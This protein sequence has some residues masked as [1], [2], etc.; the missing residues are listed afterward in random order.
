MTSIQNPIFDGHANLWAPTVATA[1]S[2]AT[3]GTSLVVQSGLGASA[4]ATPFN[5]VLYPTSA[6]NVT[7]SNSE[8]VRVTAVSTDTLTIVRSQ[9]GTTAQSVT[10]SFSIAAVVS[11][12][13]L[14][15]IERYARPNEL[16]VKLAPY[17]SSMQT[18]EYGGAYSGDTPPIY[19]QTLFS[20]DA[21]TAG[22]ITKIKITGSAAPSSTDNAMTNNWLQ[23][24]YD[25][26]NTFPFCAELGTLFGAYPG[27]STTVQSM[28]PWEA[29]CAHLST[30][31]VAQ[32]APG[33]SQ[34][35]F[36][37]THIMTYPIPFTNGILVQVFNP[38]A[39]VNSEAPYAEVTC[40]YM[41]AVD[42]PPYKLQTAGTVGIIGSSPEY[43]SFVMSALTNVGS[44]CTATIA[45]TSGII[46]GATV[47]MNA[48][49]GSPATGLT[50]APTGQC[51]VTAV[52]SS[53]QFQFTNPNGTMTGTYNTNTLVC[54]NWSTNAPPGT[55]VVGALTLM[56]P[57]GS[58]YGNIF[59]QVTQPIQSNQIAQLANITGC[60]G[61][62]VGLAYSATGTGSLTYLERNFGWYIDG[63][64]PPNTSGT[65]A[66]EYPLP[67]GSF[68]SVTG[69]TASGTTVTVTMSSSANFNVGQ[70]VTVSGIKGIVGANGFWKITTVSAGQ[71][72]YVS[73][74]A[75][76]GTY[77]SGTGTASAS[78]SPYGT[79]IGSPSMQTTGTEDTFDSAYY[80]WAWTFPASGVATGSNYPAVG[81][82]GTA[83]NNTWG[84]PFDVY[85][86]A[87]GAV[88]AVKINGVNIGMSV[89]SNSTQLVR[90]PPMGSITLSYAAGA[91]TWAWVVSDYPTG[92]PVY[93]YSS[94]CAMG[95]GNATAAHGNYYNAFL[96]ILQSA[97]GYRFTSS[98]QLWLLTESHCVDPCNPSWCLLYYVDNS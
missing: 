98:L 48:A 5:A 18:V 82:S 80:N 2:P 26:G 69:C 3:S 54:Y 40:Q 85:I 12:K 9:E 75:P 17:E 77:T 23:I 66:D 13:T 67:V 64:T 22:V 46:V 81:A 52:L 90:V 32:T 35:Y 4:P 88:D 76:T 60:A 47:E 56:E 63:A 28:G 62:A 94:P 8:L 95:V 93:T 71:I 53:T 14:T 72:Q 29:S 6:S 1:P 7:S 87:T 58:M 45:S 79:L 59:G 89:A 57:N 37:A 92:G 42:V 86:Q 30:Q 25:G 51:T 61:W 65:V 68:Q 55:N 43:I 20:A 27:N 83:V 34:A 73:T 78:G 50:N 44:T 70:M 84:V 74:T 21:G 41:N 33:G 11:K 36:Y 16:A 49:S 19:V 10:T 38:T 31:Q 91:P 96:D 39:E 24:S 15:D 97:G